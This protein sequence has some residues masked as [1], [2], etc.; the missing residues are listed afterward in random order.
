MATLFLANWIAELEATLCAPDASPPPPS[1]SAVVPIV[2]AKPVREKKEKAPK[3]EA[4]AAAGDVAPIS[5]IEFKV[6]VI[7]KVWEHETADKLYCEEIDCGEEAGPRQ[8]ASGLRPHFSL[9]EMLGQRLL[10]VANLKPKKLVGFASHGMVLCASVPDAEH[11]T[12]ERVAFVAP[13]AG[14]PL[15]ERVT[16]GALPEAP[17]ASGA[18]VDKKKLWAAASADMRTDEHGAAHWG[19]HAF[20]TSAGACTA[21]GCPNA[22]LR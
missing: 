20:L 3:A 12:G 4:A 19:E 17:P 1:A 11:A 16:Y 22:A 2:A 9:A 8:I 7:T 5:L 18:Q 10:V 14:A 21:A 6:G 13:P 15:G